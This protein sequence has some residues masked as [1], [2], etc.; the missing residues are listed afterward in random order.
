MLAYYV[1]YGVGFLFVFALIY[2]ERQKYR[3]YRSLMDM[4]VEIQFQE[5]TDPYDHIRRGSVMLRLHDCEANIKGIVIKQVSFSHNT[6]QIPILD[7]LYFRGKGDKK[8]L[9]SASFR[10]R[11]HALR[12]L[13]GKRIYIRLSGWTSDIDGKAKPFKARV[14]YTVQYAINDHQEVA[15]VV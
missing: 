7:K 8:Q 14:P 6:F 1:L 15:A 9:L 11:R 2:N 5:P 3:R 4:A 12:K 13:N 10:V